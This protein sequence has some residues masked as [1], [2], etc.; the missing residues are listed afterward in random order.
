MYPT[1]RTKKAVLRFVNKIGLKNLGDL[2]ELRRADIM[3]G[4]YKNLGRLEHFKKEID[5]VLFELPPFS[6]K[7]LEVD[8]YDVMQVLGVKPGPIV[9]SA[10]QFLFERVKE[11]R[12]LNKREILIKML[13]EEFGEIR[14]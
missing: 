8:G 14:K 6:I 4:K 10:L 11:N 12:D 13:K 1:P 2:L 9:G 7:N 5:A 3:G